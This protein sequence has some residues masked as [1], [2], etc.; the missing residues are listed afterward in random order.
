MKSL[1]KLLEAGFV[2]GLVLEDEAEV[3]CDGVFD[4]VA[5]FGAGG[6]LVFTEWGGFLITVG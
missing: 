2:T 1:V 6:R 3:V 4:L 5:S